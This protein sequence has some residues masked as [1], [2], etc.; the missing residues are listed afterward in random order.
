ML[1][2]PSSSSTAAS[3]SRGPLCARN[4]HATRLASGSPNGRWSVEL[5]LNG[6]VVDVHR[7]RF[8]KKGITPNGEAWGGLLEQCLAKTWPADIHLDPEAGALHAWVES[9][10]SKDYLVAAMCRAVDDAAWLDRCLASIDRSKL[11]D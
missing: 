10:A 11:D 3:A 2:Q 5:G 8:E 9:D 4:V 1:P 6:E 7:R